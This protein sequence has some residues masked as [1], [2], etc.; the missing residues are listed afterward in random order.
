METKTPPQPPG[1]FPTFAQPN[2]M[3]LAPI[4]GPEDPKPAPEGKGPSP[5]T[6]PMT[7]PSSPEEPPRRRR[8]LGTVKTGPGGTRMDISSAGDAPVDEPAFDPGRPARLAVVAKPDP[9]PE[10]VKLKLD[11]KLATRA[12]VVAIGIASVG[13]GLLVKWQQR[14]KATLRKPND[15]E[16]AKMATPLANIAMRHV[17][18]TESLHDLFDLFEFV[19]AA[20]AYMDNGPLLI[21]AIFPGDMPKFVEEPR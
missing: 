18:K 12:G 8:G 1:A 13:I 21:P 19:T 6:S 9:E 20:D 14:G 7:A 4:V 11:A 5:A 2:Q 15:A 17:P 3:T 10:P 16:T